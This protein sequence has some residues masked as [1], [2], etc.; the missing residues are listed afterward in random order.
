LFISQN[1]GYISIFKLEETDETTHSP[2][3]SNYLS[4]QGLNKLFSLMAVN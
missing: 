1:V 2:D 3:M 4:D